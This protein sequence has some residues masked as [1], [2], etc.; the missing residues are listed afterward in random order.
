MPLPV[1]DPT[2]I[3]PTEPGPAGPVP[4]PAR[5]AEAAGSGA[6]PST[7][8]GGDAGGRRRAGRP[9]KAAGE[10]RSERVLVS[11]KPA[12]VAAVKR[13]AEASNL[14][15]SAYVRHRLLGKAVAPR[16]LRADVKEARLEVR[17]SAA[18]LARVGSNLNQLVRW[19]NAGAPTEG[20]P[21][22]DVGAEWA[23]LAA[24]VRAAVGGVAS[25]MRAL[26][27]LGDAGDGRVH[28]G[29]PTYV[30]RP[31]GDGGDPGAGPS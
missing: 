13:E 23:A 26:S 21:R 6:P 25:T 2:E 31:A 28:G 30:G 29:G 18:E 3:R 16:Q 10:A 27:R 1:P 7:S 5:A 24:E 4:T 9:R 14:S 19:A 17:R 8:G 12:E 11:L 20:P 22:P 15:V